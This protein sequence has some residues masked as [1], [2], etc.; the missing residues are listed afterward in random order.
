MVV[1]CAELV[2]PAKRTRRGFLRPH[3]THHNA[4]VAV[5]NA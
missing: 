1:S 2:L 3:T 4:N 5:L